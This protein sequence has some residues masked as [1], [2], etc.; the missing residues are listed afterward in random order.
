MVEFSAIDSLREALAPVA[1]LRGEHSQFERWLRESFAALEGLHGELADWQRDITRQQAQLD[2]QEAAVNDASAARNCEATA[3]FERQ[4]NQARE[5]ARQLEEENADQLQ[6]LDQLERQLSIAKAELRVVT[7]QAD[8]LRRVM[9]RQAAIIDRLMGE[10]T[11][12]PAHADAIAVCTHDEASA[13]EVADDAAPTAAEL[14]RR[15]NSR[16]AA[17]RRPD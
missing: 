5:E 13:A 17:Q 1:A 14:R 10:A 2:Q 9:E 4:L 3:E 8:D 16:R 6:A 7:K 12:E 15:A 11:A